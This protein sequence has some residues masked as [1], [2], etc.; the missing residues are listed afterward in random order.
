MG[1]VSTVTL[2][3]TN[4]RD[5]QPPDTNKHAGRWRTHVYHIRDVVDVVFRHHGVGRRQVQQIV[6]PSLGAFQLVLRVLGLSLEGSSRR[7]A[8]GPRQEEERERVRCE[9]LKIH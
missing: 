6:I 9:G 7:I 4:T 2:C 1:R 3:N 5:P 8:G